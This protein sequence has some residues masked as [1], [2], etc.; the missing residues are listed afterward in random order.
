MWRLVKKL[1]RNYRKPLTKNHE[2]EEVNE[3]DKAEEKNV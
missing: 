3:P 2:K 1:K